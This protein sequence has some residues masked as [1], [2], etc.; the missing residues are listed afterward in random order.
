MTDGEASRV[1]AFRNGLM[2]RT[3]SGVVYKPAFLVGL[4]KDG[5]VFASPYQ[6]SGAW[7]Y[8]VINKDVPVGETRA[9]TWHR[10]KIHYHRSGWVYAT[11]SG[12]DL[13]QRS[14]Q[15][16]PLFSLRSSQIFSVMSL[17]T[18]ELPSRHDFGIRAGDGATAVRRW[19]DIA[20]WNVFLLEASDDE[21]RPLLLPEMQS[22]GLLATEDYTHG[23]V[24]LSAYGR[25]AVLLITVS[26]YDSWS[27]LT[28]PDGWNKPD[29]P[30]SGGT[31][32]AALPWHP[33]R[34]TSDDDGFGL[35]SASLRNPLVN[36]AS[37]APDDLTPS[38]TTSQR[39]ADEA[40]YRL[41][42]F[43]VPEGGFAPR[44]PA[45]YPDDLAGTPFARPPGD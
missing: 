6:R 45:T 40:I 33:G 32:I 21:R 16:P 13:E 20:T 41:A 43:T 5:G 30:R 39:T 2:R 11:L 25:Q 7:H 18:W 36:W 37:S 3:P 10:P 34:P 44:R 24:S 12:Q 15:L 31:T 23:I 22:M 4:S 19:P 28:Q 9:E 14:L 38:S 42:D 1:R 17:R 8:G 26:I 35:W 27:A 29:L